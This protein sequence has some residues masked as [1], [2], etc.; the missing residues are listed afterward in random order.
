MQF[1]KYD[2]NAQPGYGVFQ[3]GQQQHAKPYKKMSGARVSEVVTKS[4]PNQGVVSMHV[5][6]WNYSKS[7]GMLTVNAFENSKSTRTTGEK[8]GNQHIV[9]MFEIFYKNSGVKI[10]ELGSYNITS[11]K[12]YLS[13]INMVISTK[14]NNGGYFGTKNIKK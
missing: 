7:R 10:L 13:K 3:Q 5:N 12:V 2:R 8:N 9:L 1:K 4:G 6:A 11:G 14:A